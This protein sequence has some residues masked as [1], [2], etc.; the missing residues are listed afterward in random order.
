VWLSCAPWLLEISGLPR[1]A[2]VVLF[3]DEGHI[4]SVNDQKRTTRDIVIEKHLP[5]VRYTLAF[6]DAERRLYPERLELGFRVK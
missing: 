6:A 4:V 5:G 3:D 2:R 1:D